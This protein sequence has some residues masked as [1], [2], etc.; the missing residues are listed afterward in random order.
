M[1]RDR[2]AAVQSSNQSM[3]VELQQLK[4]EV[5]GL[6]KQNHELFKENRDMKD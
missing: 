1:D 4:V 6:Q 5:A 2:M 3:G